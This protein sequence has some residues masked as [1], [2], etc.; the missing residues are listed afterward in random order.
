LLDDSN[1]PIFST[2][3]ANGGL[4]SF[5]DLFPNSYAIQVINPDPFQYQFTLQGQG[6]TA[7]DSNVDPQTGQTSAIILT[8]GQIDTRWDAG[9]TVITTPV[10]TNSIAG[11]VWYDV[12]YNGLRDTGELPLADVSVSLVN[13]NATFFS[14]ISSTRTDNNGIY[15]FSPLPAAGNYM[16]I[17]S[18]N[19]Y[20]GV[21]P[22]DVGGDDTKDNDTAP[23]TYQAQTDVFVVGGAATQFNYDAGLYRL[24]TI[25]DFVWYD[26][27]YNGL[28]TTG[29]LGEP[30]V[31]VKLYDGTTNTVLATTFTN[32]NGNYTFKVK[33]GIYYL[34]FTVVPGEQFVVK[35]AS[36]GF[37][38][39]FF[40]SDVYQSGVNYGKTDPF[41]IDEGQTRSD[42]DC[43]MQLIPPA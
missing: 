19:V 21:G 43:G 8:Q 41:T 33:P 18:S 38:S 20:D 37:L 29:E 32:A 34:E 27:S 24:A 31:Q 14:V 1:E 23:G 2:V 25:G 4:Y 5:A 17:F 26:S 35:N 40:D 6:T 15:L 39:F 22:K 16:V 10:T 36:G 11:R 12:N 7:T 9:F 28:Q 42:I 3:T 30:N 13:V